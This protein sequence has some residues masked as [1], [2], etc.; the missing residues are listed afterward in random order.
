MIII[1]I[2]YFI[3]HFSYIYIYIYICINRIDNNRNNIILRY[4]N[5]YCHTLDSPHTTF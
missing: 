1:Q 5:F 3:K 4:K 2:Y